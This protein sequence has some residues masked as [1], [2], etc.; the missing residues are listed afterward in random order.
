M[1]FD[2]FERK[3]IISNLISGLYIENDIIHF[4]G[5]PEIYVGGVSRDGDIEI[6]DYNLENPAKYGLESVI[7]DMKAIHKTK[8]IGGKIYKTT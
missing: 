5:K 8:L 3:I 7:D 1:E 2:G 6:R 4:R